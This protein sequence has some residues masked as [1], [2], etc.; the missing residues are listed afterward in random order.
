MGMTTREKTNQAYSAFLKNG[1]I[2][3]SC[4]D[5]GIYRSTLQR[6]IQKINQKIEKTT[7]ENKSK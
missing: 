7:A 1:N 4:R 6:H 2:S 3:K 5:A